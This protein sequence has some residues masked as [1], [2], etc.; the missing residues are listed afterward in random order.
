MQEGLKGLGKDYEVYTIGSAESALEQMRTRSFDLLVVDFRL[1]GL[2]G[3]DLIEQVR[4]LDPDAKTILITAFGSP[5]IERKAYQ[6][7]ARR[8]LQ[9]PLRIEE[10]IGTVQNIFL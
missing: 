7:A 8:Y 1:P 2:N 4:D 9:K 6:L 5:E 10:L 3:L